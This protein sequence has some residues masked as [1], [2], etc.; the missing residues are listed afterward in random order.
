MGWAKAVNPKPNIIMLFVDDLGL[1]AA[2][3]QKH[4]EGEKDE[5]A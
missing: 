1:G 4:C 3:H 5:A 2:R